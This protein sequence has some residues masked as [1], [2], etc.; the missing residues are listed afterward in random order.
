M[1]YT[2]SD[3]AFQHPVWMSPEEIADPKGFIEDF[4]RSWDLADCRFYLWQMLSGSLGLGAQPVEASPGSQ[5]Y[6][7]EN[8]VA[9]VEAVYLINQSPEPAAPEQPIRQEKPEEKDSRAENEKRLIE[10]RPDIKTELDAFFYAYTL[11]DFTERLF[12]ILEAYSQN[13]YYRKSSPS[14]V[15]YAMEKLSDLIRTAHRIYQEVLEEG[16][17]LD[18]SL[19]PGLERIAPFGYLKTGNPFEAI[20]LFFKARTLEEW[21]RCIK[22]ITFFA[23]SKDEPDEGGTKEDTLYLYSVFC[24]LVEVCKAI[25]QY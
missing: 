23:L 15:L 5:L 25:K 19:K 13:D 9:M 6:F 1:R 24:G 12:F 10:G 7:F 16:S 20:T 4:C 8:L 3:S 2:A 22:H 21:E 14:D 18:F 17:S 11:K